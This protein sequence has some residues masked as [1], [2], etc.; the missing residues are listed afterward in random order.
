MATESGSGGED[1]ASLDATA[2]AELIRR[3][4]LSALEAV[5]AAIGRIEAVN[6]QI[7]AVIT[8]LYDGARAA[9]VALDRAR[10]AWGDHT[11]APFAGVPFLIKDLM[12]HTAGDRY[13]AGMPVLKAID[14]RPAHDTELAVR[15]R[16]AGLVV[17]GKTNTPEWGSLPTTEPL[18]FGATRNPWHLDHSP[19]GSSGGSAAAVASGMVPMASGGDGGGSIRVPASAC[20]LFGLKP[21][22]GRVPSG[23]DHGEVWG[24]FA[25]EGVIS[26]SVR[27]SAAALDAVAGA[28]WG[29]ANVAPPPGRP[30]RREVGAPV[31]RLRIGVLTQAPG[32]I[33]EVHPDCVVAVSDAAQLLAELGHEVETGHPAALDE[34]AE[35][36]RHFGVIVSAHAAADFD[37]WE[38]VV[39]RPLTEADI[40]P[41]DWAVVQRAKARPT[42]RYLESVTW[43]DQWR[44][45]LCSWWVDVDLLLTPTMANPPVRLGELVHTAEDPMAGM[46]KAGP[47]IVFTSPFNA[48]G[49]PAMSVPLWWNDAG[50]PVGVQLVGAPWREDVLFRVAA[51]LES[52]RPWAERR[53][54]VWAGSPAAG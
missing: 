30:Y 16:R 20:G 29:D 24:G 44:R 37:H 43:V 22:R 49:Q 36:R 17:L 31:G 50:L 26:R 39:G 1:L 13:C 8:P 34:A 28:Q 51:Q 52:A 47:S 4:E 11:L 27:D 21:A 42:G 53:P 41:V 46:A 2:Q 35:F 3:G 25:S 5:E 48:S 19:S 7:N 54:P 6:P 14:Y 9:A 23:P 10:P 12:V 40:E 18:A 15:F 33:H 38:R 32:Q 45:R